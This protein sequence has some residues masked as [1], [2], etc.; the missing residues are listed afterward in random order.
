[1]HFIL[2]LQDDVI[3]AFL[4]HCPRL[5]HMELSGQSLLTSG[6]FLPMISGKCYNCLS[7]GDWLNA[8][9][10]EIGKC[11]MIF[12]RDLVHTLFFVEKI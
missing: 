6:P 7:L 9:V 10:H 11:D 12:K 2:G 4:T 1:M 8:I 3:E 5:N